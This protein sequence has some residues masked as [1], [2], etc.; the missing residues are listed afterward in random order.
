MSHTFAPLA[1]ILLLFACS[2]G[3]DAPEQELSETIA[4]KESGFTIWETAAA[5]ESVVI[6]GSSV[7]VSHLGQKIE[8]Q[9]KD[10]DGYIARY[11]ANGRLIET[12]VDGLNS[13]KGS[14]IMGN[15]LYVADVD[16]V[17]G[18]ELESK[19][20]V[21]DVSLEGQTSFLNGLTANSQGQLYV[22]ATDVG[23]V[24]QLGSSTQKPL[25]LAEL[26]GVNGL[27]ATS[28]GKYIYAVTYREDPDGGHVFRI[29]LETLSVDQVGDYAGKLDGVSLQEERLYFTDWNPEGLG[30]VLAMDLNT[31]TVEVVA[32]DSLFQGPA[33]FDVLGDGLALIPMLTG[34]K[35][36]A[37]NLN[38]RQ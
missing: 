26:P 6:D 32:S 19:Q 7:Y 13:P 17:L 38:L 20:K 29:E 23:K 4:P 12:F 22:S 14:V 34:A 33:N 1:L 10:G 27:A 5:P 18:F 3:A 2:S 35:V 36:I 25:L 15:V 30:S 8:P 11:D 24:W 31:E 9:A 37:V 21:Y 28:E 16:H